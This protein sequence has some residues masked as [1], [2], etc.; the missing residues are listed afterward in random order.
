MPGG[1][2]YKPLVNSAARTAVKQ[3]Q[4]YDKLRDVMRDAGMKGADQ[5]MDIY[6]NLKNKPKPKTVSMSVPSTSSPT[7]IPQSSKSQVAFV[8]VD[9]P[10]SSVMSTTQMR[11]IA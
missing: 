4:Y 2:A 1:G 11:R 3:Q 10:T 9:I 8:S 7:I 5:N 6:G